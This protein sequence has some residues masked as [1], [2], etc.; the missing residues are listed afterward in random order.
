MNTTIGGADGTDVICTARDSQASAGTLSFTLWRLTQ[1]PQD[2]TGQP[3]FAALFN[4]SLVTHI[5]LRILQP[6]TRGQST[7]QVS[8]FQVLARLDCNG[9]G[10]AAAGV[11]T[12]SCV[13]NTVG[14]ACGE[15][16]P[17][18][19]G[20]PFSRWTTV[21]P[22]TCVQCACNNHATL[23]EY[24]AVLEGGTCSDCSD[25]TTGGQCERCLDGFFR[26][27]S[28]TDLAAPDVCR[29]CVCDSAG[30]TSAQCVR[31]IFSAGVGTAPG[32]CLCKAF[33]IGAQCDG[34]GPGFANLD[35]ANPTGCS[36]CSACSAA[37]STASNT[38]A[39]GACDCK[40]NVE[41]GLCDTCVAGY[42][43][44]VASNPVGCDQCRCDGAGATD[45]DCDGVTGQCTCRQGYSGL[46]CSSCAD[47]FR[48]Q[49]TPSR[50]GG[51]CVPCGCSAAGSAN[52]SCTA[53]G[54]CVCRTGYTGDQCDQCTTGY[55]GGAGGACSA[56]ACDS[57]GTRGDSTTC[58]A[59]SGQCLCKT[60][61]T[62]LACD[63]CI[64]S[65]SVL[66]AAN[67]DGCSGNPAGLVA[68]TA[69]AGGSVDNPTVVLVWS[70]PTVSAG[71][72]TR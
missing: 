49:S 41:G 60:F 55:F 4:F 65:F 66:D 72:I 54:A 33:V 17:L 10:T 13:H 57:A 27:A 71:P 5:R 28:I 21:T 34:C 53:V 46:D 8:S 37:G 23:C 11:R 12:C 26:P 20:A 64:P 45:N 58:N 35:A 30:A 59:V 62:G 24:D 9:H 32:D 18:A 70:A 7:Y 44:L 19:N 39:L 40:V 3:A 42:T 2:I 48:L 25:N 15:C 14:P 50:P 22:S 69:V 6:V 67:V 52:A 47:G 36:A 51:E 61:A 43:N 16:A 68:P 63:T 56:C 38:C 29:A 31:D 1:R